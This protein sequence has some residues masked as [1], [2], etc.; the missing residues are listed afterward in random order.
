LHKKSIKLCGVAI[1]SKP[2][3]LVGLSVDYQPLA[4]MYEKS[5]LKPNKKQICAAIAS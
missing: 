4:S 3:Q 5:G 2:C 1:F